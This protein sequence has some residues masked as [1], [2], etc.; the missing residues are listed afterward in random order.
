MI[1]LRLASVAQACEPDV[2]SAQPLAFG[3]AGTGVSRITMR[4]VAIGLRKIDARNYARRL[5]PFACASPAL[6]NANVP[7]P[8]T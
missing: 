2:E 5:R 1:A 7:Q 3:F 4:N 8:T 6:I